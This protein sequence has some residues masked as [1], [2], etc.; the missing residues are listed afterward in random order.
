MT[1]LS[2]NFDY[3]AEDLNEYADLARGSKEDLNTSKA[4]FS[5]FL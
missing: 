4:Y 5:L 3:E 1:L 2:V